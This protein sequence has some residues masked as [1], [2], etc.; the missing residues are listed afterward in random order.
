ME[1]QVREAIK[2]DRGEVSSR[3][4]NQELN[5]KGVCS[6]HESKAQGDCCGKAVRKTT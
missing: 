6:D 1:N 3:E 2:Q 5:S 4:S